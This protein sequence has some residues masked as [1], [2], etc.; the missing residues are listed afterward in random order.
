MISNGGNAATTTDIGSIE[1]VE[2]N[3]SKKAFG[4]WKKKKKGG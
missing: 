2:Y 3:N 4:K 1:T